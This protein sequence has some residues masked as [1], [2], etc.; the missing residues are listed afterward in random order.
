MAS[1]TM[2][3]KSDNQRPV[4]YRTPSPPPHWAIEPLTPL[5]PLPP[6]RPFVGRPHQE[7]SP[8]DPIRGNWSKED[9]QHGWGSY[10]RIDLVR[11]SDQTHAGA[12][13][14]RGTANST[15]NRDSRPELANIKIPPNFSPMDTFATIA[16]AT[17]PPFDSF[18]EL[19]RQA[20]PNS[21]RQSS[22]RQANG[23]TPLNAEG[24]VQSTIESEGRPSKRARSE[25]TYGNDTRNTDI[26]PATS[27]VAGVRGHDGQSSGASSRDHGSSEDMRTRAAAVDSSTDDAELLLH[28]SR[29]AWLS[30]T[31]S[32][33]HNDPTRGFNLPNAAHSPSTSDATQLSRKLRG[34]FV[35]QSEKPDT[36]STVH[37]LPATALSYGLG[38]DQG[39][40]L[41][42]PSSDIPS[43]SAVNN[44]KRHGGN[45]GIH[46]PFGY[47]V[48]NT[49][50][51]VAFPVNG[52]KINQVSP[53]KVNNKKTPHI[54]RGWPKGKPRGPR[55]NWPGVLKSKESA[56][57]SVQLQP[58]SDSSRD[59]RRTPRNSKP[60]SLKARFA[61][62]DPESTRS[63]LVHRLQSLARG[64]PTLQ[65][66]MSAPEVA[67]DVLATSGGRQNQSA[68]YPVAGEVTHSWRS[69]SAPPSP[70]LRNVQ[71]VEL[72]SKEGPE[73]QG[74]G[75]Q[76]GRTRTHTQGAT[77]ANCE[78]IPNSLG[79]NIETEDVSWISCDGCKR[80]FHFAC[81][82]LTEK[83]VRSVDKFSC[84]D[85]WNTHGPTTYV[86]KSSRAHTAIDYAGLNEGV[87]KTSDD[88][89][90]HPY[91]KPIKD[92]T[93]SFL[94]EN[95]ARLRPELVT[96]DFFETGNGMKEPV[97]IPAW[98]NPRPEDPLYVN[99]GATDEPR[100][101][102][103]FSSTISQLAI[104]AML[105]RDY[106]CEIVLDRGQDALDMVMP[107]DLTVRQ[108]SQLYGPQ[109]KV[110]VIDVKSQGEA[111]S[112]NM[113]K[114]ADYYE[115]A[116]KKFIRNV[117]SL[118]ISTSKLGRLVRRPQVV[119]EL[120]LVDSVWPAE[121]KAKGDFP[122]VQLY[123]LMSVA[124]SFTDFHID[125][126]G[127][128]VFYHI[129][130]GKKTFLFIPPKNKHLKKYEQ[131]CLSPAQNQ[132]FLPDQTKECYRVDLSAGDTMLIPSG[133][134]HAVWTPEESLVI[135]GNFLTR[136]HYGMQI[137]VAEIEKNT[138]VP[139]KFRHPHFQRV[140]WYTA[141]NYLKDDPLPQSVIGLF[142]EGQMFVREVPPYHEYEQWG[143]NS[144]DGPGNFQAR[145]YSQFELDGLPDL[146]RYLLRTALIAMGNVTEGIT[147]D[148]RQRVG[149]AI[150]KGH[151]EPLEVVKKFALWC[152]W[153][154]GN[155]LI[156][157]WAY[158]NAIPA[159]TAATVGEKKVS[160]AAIKR[161]ERE[162]ALE[163]YRVAPERQ[164]ARR[165]AQAQAAA[166]KTVDEDASK[167]E[168]IDSE[169]LVHPQENGKAK[170][171]SSRK[172]KAPTATANGVMTPKSAPK[173]SFLGPKRIACEA[174]RR[175]RIGCKHKVELD[176]ADSPISNDPLNQAPNDVGEVRSVMEEPV[177]LASPRQI[178]ENK[179]SP[180][181]SARPNEISMDSNVYHSTATEETMSSKKGR[182]KACDDCRKS[183]RRC[184]HDDWGNI[185]AVKAQEASTKRVSAA[186][187]RNR[188]TRE[189][190]HTPS[191]R[192]KVAGQEPTGLG[193]NE[194]SS[195]GD[196]IHV[197]CV[198]TIQVVIPKRS[199]LEVA[200][201]QDR[202]PSTA[203]PGPLLD[204]VSEPA[205]MPPSNEVASDVQ[206]KIADG[207]GQESAATTSEPIPPT[208]YNNE[209]SA[210]P[211][212]DS[213]MAIRGQ[214][215]VLS[216]E[217]V[218]MRDAEE[219]PKPPQAASGLVAD[220]VDEVVPDTTLIAQPQAQQ[221]QDVH[222][223]EDS[224]AM[225]IEVDTSV[226]LSPP[227]VQP[228]DN[229]QP[230]NNQT[231]QEGHPP[232]T[233]AS[234]NGPPSSLQNSL[235]SE[236]PTTQPLSPPL[237][238]LTDV[239]LL[240]SPRAESP[241]PHEAI[242]AAD[243]D[244]SFRRS[245]RASKPVQTFASETLSG[246]YPKPRPVKA[247]H[248]PVSIDNS[249]K[250]TSPD[251]EQALVDLPR[252]QQS[253]SKTPCRASVSASAK[254]AS[255]AV[256]KDRSASHRPVIEVQT[257][258]PTQQQ[259]QATPNS[260]ATS[261]GK[262][263]QT[264]RRLSMEDEASLRM[265]KELTF[266]LRQRGG[267]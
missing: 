232:E 228:N 18:S 212:L 15:N 185:D 156:P 35:N 265:A 208:T 263:S 100:D 107:K 144:R 221:A 77:C 216:L 155:E 58:K 27:H 251:A 187:K 171:R 123:C 62:E 83:E 91:I 124:D 104:K 169:A 211:C 73:L 125:F 227:Q 128:S 65:R 137:Q 112:W 229:D 238:P 111:G 14:S 131:W 63:A 8:Q 51:G 179:S 31:S 82:G 219:I 122:K 194:P 108:V 85:C 177:A 166:T 93:I 198:P 240:P 188:S 218:A 173:T 161:L 10:Q 102:R 130:K 66:R 162:A 247:G 236:E 141:I 217:D 149:R 249:A 117:I 120:D 20:S 24:L 147:A 67:D 191:K 32:V 78:M 17:S 28:V 119:R 69:F 2:R 182:S 153:K 178:Y 163:A 103:S 19:P 170:E 257:K 50:D 139:R 127:S 224:G 223:L 132:T 159:D 195:E 34:T 3:G 39:T 5:S 138:K 12:S 258:T 94:E 237:S 266:G 129:L 176:L 33:A 151:G 98:M 243:S 207:T 158:P 89:P 59:D 214:E 235:P 184:I 38:I 189:L 116:Q 87:V 244:P 152:A 183:K 245:G 256:K 165:Q 45:P 43:A 7:I 109:E 21:S 255:P 203:S 99:Y 25:E 48:H 201:Y 267:R 74:F 110:D 190:D 60:S 215:A 84:A 115:S 140:L 175:R 88:N 11:R 262:R 210:L 54:N 56:F 13:P 106:D 121:L 1:F 172:R 181:G 46:E 174:C 157:H 220:D 204:R 29:V 47:A 71:S 259:P 80:W 200:E 231:H 241:T 37:K 252:R 180:V 248:T 164:S 113:Q 199:Q 30:P 126:G 209:P 75:S 95:F 40:H 146:L 234:S 68:S 97:V 55:G 9:G 26:R 230:N 239:D 167:V 260:A 4:D 160:A 193:A 16:L 222:Q 52:T 261:G 57:S 42:G 148:A 225:K 250:S 226:Q 22:A 81:A 64:R 145:Y 134:I 61:E 192:A 168:S 118:E 133:W 41:V 79:R 213:S 202:D 72:I 76:A 36:S 205:I 197:S 92:G 143:S 70:S 242:P 90:E 264:P 196:I 253:R 96:L 53:G 44:V 154:R 23:L 136:M 142:H 186:A 150:P 6:S 114:W 49:S 206:S 233:F 254:S 105:S 101:E 135:G 246:S 86:R